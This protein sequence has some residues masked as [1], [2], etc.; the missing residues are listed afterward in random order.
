MRYNH[1]TVTQRA[2]TQQRTVHGRET[3]GNEAHGK[4]ARQLAKKHRNELGKQGGTPPRIAQ[5]T[6]E[7]DEA[8]G[9]ERLGGFRLRRARSN[10]TTKPAKSIPMTNPGQEDPGEEREGV[11]STQFRERTTHMGTSIV[12][13]RDG[14]TGADSIPPSGPEEQEKLTSRVRARISD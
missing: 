9:V 8:S 13:S 3:S 1:E 14:Y 4:A 7:C 12:S 11:N 5:K 6:P 2:E 10:Q